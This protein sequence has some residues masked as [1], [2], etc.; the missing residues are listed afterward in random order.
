MV[1]TAGYI[2][3][4]RQYRAYAPLPSALN[5]SSCP[6]KTKRGGG[7]EKIGSNERLS[8]GV[9]CWV[10]LF[11]SNIILESSEKFFRYK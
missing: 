1:P 7:G 8:Y 5:L 3:E 2:Y 9:G 6:A 10:F 11:W 4:Y